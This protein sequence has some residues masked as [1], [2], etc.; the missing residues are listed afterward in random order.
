MDKRHLADG[1]LF[2]D[3]YQLT[4]AQLFYRN[5]LHQKTAQFDYFFRRYPDYGEHRAGY[6]ICAG[7]ENLLE[8]MEKSRFGKVEIQC[9]RNQ[10]GRAGER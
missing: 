5:G 6:C 1:I 8:W 3:F 7:L 10:K 9:L 4:M 2:T